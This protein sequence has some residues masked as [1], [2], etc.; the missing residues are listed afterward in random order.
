MHTQRTL[1]LTEKWD[2]SLD[3]AGDLALC[4]EAHAV[5]QNVAT[6]CRLFSKDAY[7]AADLGISHFTISLGHS[8]GA[9]LRAQLRKAALGVF[10]VLQVNDIMLKD[11]NPETRTLCGSI[12]FTL[13]S[14]ENVR[15]KL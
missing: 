4:N 6:E 1:A 9:A 11:F 15:I 7:F 13:R 12:G 2:I 14:G 8:Q 3:P 10:G 5:A